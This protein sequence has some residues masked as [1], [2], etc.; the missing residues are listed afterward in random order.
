MADYSQ[1]AIYHTSGL[2]LGAVIRKTTTSNTGD[3]AVLGYWNHEAETWDAAFDA[4]N[5]VKPLKRLSPDPAHHDY[6]TQALAVPYKPF[7]D[8]A[9][10]CTIYILEDGQ[11]KD[12]WCSEDRMAFGTRANLGF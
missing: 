4:E 11:P 10:V 2:P 12:A 5:H 1:S 3:V 7:A 6:K 9:T 8:P